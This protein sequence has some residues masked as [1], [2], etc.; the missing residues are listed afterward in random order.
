VGNT[1]LDDYGS[2]GFYTINGSLAGTLPVTQ[3][4]LSGLNRKGSHQLSWLYE[5]DETIEKMEIE[6]SVDGKSFVRIASVKGNTGS[7]Q[8][9]SP[10][11]LLRYYRLLL[12]NESKHSFYSN[13]VALQGEFAK[14]VSLLNSIIRND[15]HVHVAKSYLYQ[16]Y[17]ENGALLKQGHLAPGINRIATIGAG[18]GLIILKLFNETEAQTFKLIKQ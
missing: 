2:V 8:I 16:L 10:D 4:R 6:G 14:H 15:I 5:G 9:Q 11:H 1:N 3:F 12:V 18:K 17:N 13:I 7:H